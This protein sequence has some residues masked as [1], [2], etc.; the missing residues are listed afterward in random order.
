MA[1][2]LCSSDSSQEEVQHVS[3]VLI[4]L[5]FVS[6]S[7]GLRRPHPRLKI[8]LVPRPG[9]CG[10][11]L[12]RGG[13]R[14]RTRVLTLVV[15]VITIER[16]IQ[17]PLPSVIS[18]LLAS[19]VTHIPV[20]LEFYPLQAIGDRPQRR[21]LLFRQ[22][23]RI[24]SWLLVLLWLLRRLALRLPGGV[25]FLDEGH[26]NRWL[27][28]LARGKGHSVE[29][30]EAYNQSEKPRALLDFSEST[31]CLVGAIPAN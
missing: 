21:Y 12:L 15:H 19:H 29:L 24:C 11:E 6:T 14:E 7:G 4:L 9:N 30:A 16:L 26:I 22:R 27:N 8:G 13:P 31:R 5:G 17:M 20:Y 25:V 18:H 3:H 28:D 2:R 1:T 10:L 23:W